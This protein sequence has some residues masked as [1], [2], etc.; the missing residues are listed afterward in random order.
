MS[1][2][3]HISRFTFF[4]LFCRLRQLSRHTVLFHAMLDAC[5]FCCMLRKT[6]K[7]EGI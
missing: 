4:P 1:H 2:A 3:E 7:K 5:N 6:E